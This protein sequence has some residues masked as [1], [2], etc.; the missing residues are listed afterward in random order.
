MTLDFTQWLT[1]RGGTAHS[2]AARDAGFSEHTVRTAVAA[3]AARRV[4]RSWLVAPDADPRRLAAAQVSGR[5]TCVSAASLLGLWTPDHDDTHI[6]VSSHASRLDDEGLRLH[7]AN[8]PAPVGPRECVDPLVNVL[9]H[10]ARCTPPRDALAVWES[11][12]RHGRIDI[13]TLRR[14]Q[15]R[16]ARARRLADLASGLSD[17]GIETVF[18]SLMRQAGIRVVQ[19]AVVDGHRVDG[20]IGR[21]L[22]V[23]IDGF[24]HH[25]GAAARRRDLAQ[26]ARLVV[27]GFTVLRFDYRQLLFESAAVID[28]VRTAVAQGLD[29]DRPSAR[30]GDRPRTGLPL[31]FPPVTAR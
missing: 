16:S 27:R 2:S 6:A 13:D 30:T 24:A 1:D 11:A 28:T 5:L 29:L 4:R 26:D 14:V 20:R 18:V 8:V 19:Q 23:Q 12:V 15:W 31:S 3:G 7:R 22:I 21:R 25:G 10:V 17:S 9:F